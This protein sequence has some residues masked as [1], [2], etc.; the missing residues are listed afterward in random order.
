MKSI[1]TMVLVVATF[2]LALTG[3]GTK[4]EETT[5]PV[6]EKVVVK[7]L[8]GET[9]VPADPKKVVV[10]S[11]VTWE[12]SLVSV[13]VKPYAVMTY[14][15]QF[16]PHLKDQLSEVVQIP[17][18]DEISKEEI[19]KLEP[20]LLIVSDRYKAVYD[21]LATVI[22]T[23]AIEVGGDWKEDHLKLTEAVGKK[24]EGEAVLASLKEKA[25]KIGSEIKAKIGDKN[26]MAVS[27]NKKDIRVYGKINHAVNEL[28]YDDLQLTPTKNL[29]DDFGVNISIEGLLEYN[30]DYILD[31]SY[32][33][34]G[35]YYD[36]V[37]KGDVW[38][39]LTA[40]KNKNVYQLSTTWG[41]WDP[42]ERE[43]ALT[44]IQKAFQ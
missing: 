26:V 34:S 23:V 39:S 18:A 31:L 8:Y 3:C 7:H 24:A 44:E 15:G 21:E 9:E 10:L 33:N 30:P 36:S 35:E 38:N 22:P 6:E 27:I 4:K 2:L 37:T 29:P 43:K 32:F 20:D 12:G 41:L 14:D 42:I 1:R 11:H 17:Y 5:A 19:L 25:E 13:G 16:A 40:V 28:L